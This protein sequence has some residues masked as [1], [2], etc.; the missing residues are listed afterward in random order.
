MT[1]FRH[2]SLTMSQNGTTVK[3]I[4]DEYLRFKAYFEWI[5]EGRPNG[6]DKEHWSYAE[7]FYRVLCGF[8]IISTESYKKFDDV[9]PIEQRPQES[10]V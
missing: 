4:P 9:M 10:G 8:T 5:E 2:Y 6:R 3:L 7:W 1:Y